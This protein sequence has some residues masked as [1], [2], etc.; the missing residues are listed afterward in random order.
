MDFAVLKMS[1]VSKSAY[2]LLCE[3]IW[4]H[5]RRYFLENA[6]TISDYEFDQLFTRLVEIEKV[7]PEWVFSGSPTQKTEGISGGFLVAQH[8]LP[9]LSLANTYSPE[10]IKDFLERMEKLL[11][12]KEIL[13][14]AELKMDGIAVAIHYEEGVFKRGLTRGNGKEGEDISQNLLTIPTLPLHL[15]PGAPTFVEARGEVFMPLHAF[16]QLNRERANVGEALF[17]N[18]RNAA[19]GSLKLLDSRLVAKRHLDIVFY[20][21]GEE[22][23]STIKSHFEGLQQLKKWGLPVVSEA[24]IGR[25]FEE[26]WTFAKRIEKKRSQ[27]PFE[28]DG[29]VIKVDSIADQ[30]KLGSTGKNY[31]WAIAYKFCPERAE[32][33]IRAITVQVGRTGVLTPVAELEPVFLAGSTIA[34]A[35][36][37]NEDEIVRKDIRLGDLAY[38]EKGGDVIPKVVGINLARRPLDSIPWTMPTHCPACGAKVVRLEGEVALRCPDSRNCP[39]Q[40]KKRIIFFAGKSGMDIEHMGEKVVT[41]LVELELIKRIS[42]IYRLTAEDLSKLRNFKEK[43]IQN[44]LTSIEAS[45]KVSLSRFIMALGIKHVGLETAELLAERLGDWERIAKSGREELMLIEGIGEKVADSIVS[46]FLDRDNLEEI[47]RLITFGVKPEKVSVQG[48]EEH[49]FFG[50]TFVLTGALH[51][52][53]RDKAASLIRERGGKIGNSVTKNCDYL[54]IGEEPGS[55]LEKAKKFNIKII[56]EQEFISAL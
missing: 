5:N 52:F 27:L 18:P 47:E 24:A 48:F 19:G 43:A 17:A 6:P 53:T 41:Q 40:E 20:G 14:A 46:F 54:L 16:E 11:H 39:A 33:V 8:H 26:L 21:M 28:I 36:L 23:S 42:D 38:I 56:T 51:Q 30:K 9:M 13:Y 12:K 15:K 37:H 10:E 32:T 2:F 3:T 29:V 35:S 31:R 22:S 1:E 44:L 7:H 4:E 25:N 50:K 45:K 55:K 34:R 49:P